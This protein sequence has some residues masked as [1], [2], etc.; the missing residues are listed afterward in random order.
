MQNVS[1][2]TVNGSWVFQQTANQAETYT[3]ILETQNTFLDK[4]ISIKTIIPAAATPTLAITDS[5]ADIGI[6]T[7]SSGYYPL[8]ATLSGTISLGTAGWVTAAG[9]S[10]SD[11]ATVGRIAQSTLKLGT[12]T[13]ASGYE[14]IP[15][16]TD[17][18]INIG[19]GYNTARSVTVK[20]VSAGQ[21]AAAT[22]SISKAATAPTLAN[23]T[24]TINGLTQVVVSPTATAPSTG[25]YYI[26]V[27]ATAPATALST[28]TNGGITRSVDTAGYLGAVAQVSASGSTTATSKTFYAPLTSAALAVTMSGVTVNPNALNNIA[29]T[30]TNKTQITVTPSSGTTTIDKYFIAVQATTPA[31]NITLTK[32]TLTAGYLGNANQITLPSNPKTTAGSST[33]YIP[34]TSGALS[35]G[36]G[37]ANATATNMQFNGAAT[38]TAPS[39]G[40]F[41][42]VTGSGTVGVG[43]SGWIEDTASLSSNTAT[44]YYKVK[45]GAVSWNQSTGVVTVTEGYVTSGN[46]FSLGNGSL[47]ATATSGTTYAENTSVVLNEQGYLYINPGYMPA[48]KISLATMIPD[49]V[50]Y[51][52]AGNS[53]ILQNYEAYDTNGAKLIGSIPTYAGAYTVG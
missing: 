18:V 2:N 17:Q 53:H 3:G 7:V 47:S 48:T 16:S 29:K 40:P 33:Y 42:T 27:A 37:V 22:V 32:G 36:D 9:L 24:T 50:N 39:S 8:T 21:Q 45:Q 12:T 10:G 34:V 28:E 38:T 19:M 41:I 35:A 11:S 4:N 6:G 14:V 51:T 20:A 43:T 1:M 5:N 52:N 13:I 25:D 31:T 23:T 30:L 46:G 44:K 26:S 49:D 15:G